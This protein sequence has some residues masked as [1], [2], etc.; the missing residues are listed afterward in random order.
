MESA[1][2]FLENI[3]GMEVDHFSFPYGKHNNH[4]INIVKKIYKSNPE[5]ISI[6]DDHKHLDQTNE[7]ELINEAEDTMTI[8]RKYIEGLDTSVDK[9]KLT[10]LIGSLY[11]EAL[12]YDG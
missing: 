12:H 6:V 11:N 7:D 1:Q 4:L 2:K 9:K 3:L 8:M 5:N 10:S